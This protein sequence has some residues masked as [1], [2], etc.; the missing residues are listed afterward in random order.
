M[1]SKAGAQEKGSKRGRSSRF[2]WLG[3]KPEDISNEG[4]HV[5]YEPDLPEA[6]PAS[7]SAVVLDKGG[8]F[9]V[10]PKTWG[11]R[12]GFTWDAPED[13]D[14]DASAAMFNS[15]KAP[16]D[17]VW[18]DHPKTPEESVIF[19]SKDHT[20]G[21]DH[22]DKEVIAVEIDHLPN[23]V[24]YIVLCI[25]VYSKG[26]SLKDGVKSLSLRG[27]DHEAGDH[28]LFTYKVDTD[29]RGT[30]MLMGVLVRQGAWFKFLPLKQPLKS[31]TVT[32]LTYA[33]GDL[34]PAFEVE[35]IP[36]ERRRLKLNV[37]EGRDLTPMD[38]SL[39]KKRSDPY[40]KIFYRGKFF[41]SEIQYATLE[42]KYNF[43][44][45]DI[46]EVVE[47][48]DDIIEIQ[49]WDWDKLTEDDFMG[50]VRICVGGV[51][52]LG[53]G[54]HDTWLPVSATKEQK[55]ENIKITGE[56]RFQF[57]MIN[58]ADYDP[59]AEAAARKAAAAAEAEKAGQDVAT[60]MDKS[61]R[62]A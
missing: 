55:E 50:M 26:K 61:W 28:E 54:E 42:P 46:G 5:Y 20:H 19:T 2:F 11:L 41:K 34:Q 22:G 24:S 21:D 29:L 44:P 27:F 33:V 51:C 32:E 16:M 30:S 60:I 52:Q 37:S 59:V 45:L 39:F 38:I 3:D 18:W 48:D 43:A 31:R 40:L 6:P 9:Q 1:A 25:S 13:L 35:A 10:P 47:C 36:L 4:V 14:L 56:L 53:A 58:E 15:I 49:V 8:E 17:Y 23:E 12:L 62:H 57:S 7:Q